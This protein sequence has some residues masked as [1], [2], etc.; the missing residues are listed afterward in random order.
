MVRDRL[1]DLQ[2]GQAEKTPETPEEIRKREKSE[3]KEVK[4][5]KKKKEKDLEKGEGG[6]NANEEFFAEIAKIRDEVAI[7]KQDIDQI[8]KIHQ[9]ALNVISEKESNEKADELEKMMDKTNKQS[10]LIRNKLKQMDTVNKT[11]AKDPKNAN[12]VRIRLS[13]HGAVAKK[14]LDVM[15]EYKSIQTKYQE[16]YKQR[17][18]RQ[19]LIVKPTAT[20]EEIQEVLENKEEAVPIFAQQVLSGGQKTEAKR[21]LKDIQDRH[22]DILRIEKSIMELQQLFMDMSVLVAAQGELLNA[23]D[24]HVANAVDETE[25]GIT[26]LKGAVK[27]QKKTRKKMCIII[28]CLVILSVAIGVAVTMAKRS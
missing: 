22:T 17:M 21:A 26:Q 27:L 8:D 4:E 24:S 13:Q 14:F 18:Q 6:G 10:A 23:I 20:Q 15:T 25:A 5:Q 11:L 2:Q 19:F 16:K 9:Q 7:I 1:G 28:C 12:D 3:Q